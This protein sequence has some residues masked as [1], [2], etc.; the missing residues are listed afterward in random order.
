M[1]I[2]KDM[3]G[4]MES[5]ENITKP[6]R[7]AA[8]SWAQ[9]DHKP[10]Q[11]S[12]LRSES[13]RGRTKKEKHKSWVPE[14]HVPV[15]VGQEMERFVVNA[16][17]LNHPVFVALLKRSAQEYG[18]EQ[19]GVL[20]I[21]CHVLVFERILESL[22]LGLAESHDLH[23]VGDGNNKVF[24]RAA[25]IRQAKNTIKEI[26]CQDGRV[27]FEE[28]EI[29]AEAEKYFRDFLQLIPNDF[30]GTTVE[31]LQSLLPFR[32]SEEDQQVLTS[33]VTGEE[34]K[35]VLFSMPND[36]SLGP[37]GFTSEFYKATWGL[38]GKEF[39][40]A[41][42]SFFAKGFLPTGINSTILALIPKK[43]GAR[44]MK[45]YRPI[46]CC[47]VIYKVIS[48]IIANRLK[49]I[50]PKFIAGNQS[51]FV[52]DRLLIE[53]L[54]LATE[55]VKDYH[56]DAIST[57]CA[58]KIDI[59]KAFD[60]VQWSFLNKVLSALNFPPTFIHWIMLCVTTASFS[61]QVNG[62]L[63]G[64][65]RSSRGLRQGCS[66]SPYLFVIVMDVLSK[67]LDKAAEKQLFGYHPRCKNLGITHLSFADDLMVL[68]DGKVHS[69]EGIIGVFDEFAKHSGLKISL[70]KSTLY[71]AGMSS[72]STQQLSE[73]YPFDI[74]R[75]PV[76]YLGLPLV[77][78]RF[79]TADYA[80][81]IEQIR[82]RINS[83][84]AR[85]LSFAGR[86]NLISSVLWSICNFWL[87]AFRL[88][89]ECIEGI[90]KLCSSFLWSGTDLQPHKAKISWEKV[91]TPKHEG[92]LGLRSLKE[93]NNVSCLKLIWRIVSQGNSLWVKWIQTNLLKKASFWSLNNNTSMGS[94]IWK[95]LLKYREVAKGFCKV[96]VGNGELTSFWFDDWSPMNR[97][98]DTAGDRGIIDM[99][100]SRQSS[101]A[102]AWTGRRR[103]RH[104][105]GY[106][107]LME[108]ALLSQR[109]TRT[110]KV[111]T[112][113]WRGKNDIFQPKFSTKDT[114]N[115]IRT[116]SNTVSWSKGVWFP[117][118]T[119]KYSFCMWL[120]A[121]DRLS[122][123]DRMIRWNGG[124]T[125][126]CVFCQNCV[127]TRDHL[128]FACSFTSGIWKT[129][130]KGILQARFTTG[131]SQLID[132][133][134]NN[135]RGRVESFLIRYA[136]QTTVYMIWRERN[137]RRH[138][139]DQH[140]ELLITKWI[141][142]QV[143]NRIT[144]L[145][146]MGDRRYDEAY[147]MWLA[148]RS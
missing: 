71:L 97:L 130:A 72:S 141:D 13:Q 147:Q 46:S 4:L 131:W 140:S 60:S 20:R 22:R 96:E 8:K 76:R 114:W 100:I 110:E 94:W 1:S 63:A 7:Y 92:G 138:G 118:N 123:G 16:E 111:D 99:G 84:S 31:K 58:I 73:K 146:R 144:T 139:Q 104:R 15:Y 126:I 48:K 26:L 10:T 43:K 33:V 148:T 132:H 116:T 89:K 125:G 56:K 142:K 66:L 90:G 69:V 67:M 62:A 34:V 119:P 81:L 91:S 109:Q 37:D 77:T 19:Q 24:H 85:S 98:F 29:K 107:N 70:E 41:V 25:A 44:E 18:Y 54:L 49:R 61:V 78:K 12:L 124:A 21:P 117:H 127:E 27:V 17:L 135:H 122:T 74:G 112:V 5:Y 105:A 102:Q 45:D 59:S 80:P 121:H 30:E 145:R 115:H 113:V 101:V 23:A 83:W 103:R 87:A 3:N 57:R 86:L 32:C 120:A 47:N 35:K 128:F 36:K 51:A 2:R 9:T 42:Q 129:T 136:L 14:G 95:K 50:L 64:Y 143:R 52:Q 28:D 133:V 137:G 75:L 68:S 53:N 82:Q 38:I 79:A 55:L 108:A 93:A 134:S 40:L 11:Y 6:V 65:F 39:T 106:L 88:P